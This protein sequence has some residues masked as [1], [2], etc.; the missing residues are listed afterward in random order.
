MRCTNLTSKFSLWPWIG[1]ACEFFHIGKLGPLLSFLFC[2]YIT[3]YFLLF[4]LLLPI[5]SFPPT[6]SSCSSSSPFLLF[7]SPSSSSN[8][9]FYVLLSENFVG[10]VPDTNAAKEQVRD[11]LCDMAVWRAIIW[12]CQASLHSGSWVAASSKNVLT[13]T[14]WMSPSDQWSLLLLMQGEA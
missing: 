12:C 3:V 11:T 6:F 2:D 14:S 5:P 8:L 1:K 10:F 4:L 9:V 7:L 13:G